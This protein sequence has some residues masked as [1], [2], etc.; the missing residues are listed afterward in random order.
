MCTGFALVPE[1]DGVGETS[2]MNMPDRRITIQWMGD[3]AA[4]VKVERLQDGSWGDMTESDTKNPS[5]KVI[6]AL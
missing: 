6:Y 4:H 5:Q 1:G 3:S 2:L